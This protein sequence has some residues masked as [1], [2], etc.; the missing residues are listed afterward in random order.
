MEQAQR[1]A[2]FDQ[3]VTHGDPEPVEEAGQEGVE[4]HD[5]GVV[6][7]EPP[8]SS[9]VAAGGGAGGRRRLFDGSRP[10][11]RRVVR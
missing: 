3:I 10:R 7:E 9:C 6:D 4:E 11:A 8:E 5:T 1:A 2:G